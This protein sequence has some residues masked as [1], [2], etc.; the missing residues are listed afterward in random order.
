MA[1]AP[2]PNDLTR[3]QLDELDALLQ[4]ML[5][6]PPNSPDMTPMPSPVGV[7]FAPL[8][9]PVPAP[10]IREPA[11][12]AVPFVPPTRRPDPPAPQL[13]AAPISELPRPAA[14]PL[15]TPRNPVAVARPTPVEPP[16]PQAEEPTWP[17]PTPA[18]SPVVATAPVAAPTEPV[19][20]LLLPLVGVNSVV[21]GGLG[22]L[23]FPGRVLR[24]GFVKNLL[25]LVGLG[26]IAYTALKVAS[27]HLSLPIS[28][29]WP[30]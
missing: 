6:L 29:P 30:R 23:G 10:P 17:T 27:L 19:S 11:P 5:S 28:L 16:P 3:Q 14:D 4:R 2:S 12:V 21:N 1:T 25:G 13:L 9:L 8:P 24:S 20:I 26:L 22:L 7:E 18:P 15:P